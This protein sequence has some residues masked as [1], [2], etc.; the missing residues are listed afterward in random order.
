M[1]DIVIIGNINVIGLF[2]LN[3][4]RVLW[5]HYSGIRNQDTLW[6]A[7]VVYMPLYY[8]DISYY[9][10]NVNQAFGSCGMR[11]HSIRPINRS[12]LMQFAL[13]IS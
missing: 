13:Q 9:L 8:S 6:G 4:K 10:R 11:L 7:T 12:I 3:L 2:N 5:S 1:P